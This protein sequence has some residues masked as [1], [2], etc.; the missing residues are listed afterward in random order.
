L[1]LIKKLD[2]HIIDLS[3]VGIKTLDL[4]ISSP[5]IQHS[6]GN[7]EGA[8]GAIDFGS[9]IG[10]RQIVGK[11]RAMSRDIPTFSL[12][13]DEVFA[14]LGSTQSFY[15]I[16]KRL[17]G[18]QWLVKTDGSF[19]IP[20]RSIFGNFEVHFIAIKGVA[21]SIMT[22]QQLQTKKI[23]T[24]DETWSWGMGLET[25]DDSEL[26]YNHTITPTVPIKIFNAGNVEVHPFES[27]LKITIK[28][29]VGTLGYLMLVNSNGSFIYIMKSVANSEVWI[30][31]GPNVK[32]NSLVAIQDTYKSFIHL[33]PGWNT[34]KLILTI[35]IDNVLVLM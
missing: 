10:T 29:V 9:T 27:Y 22:T 19:D 7:V 2:G 20:Q 23:N 13:R 32:R 1:V 34:L 35:Y 15:L 11:F 16:E 14:I 25:V 28:N 18:K 21:E 12:L 31:D 4:L 5:N 33:D 30:F 26:V 8:M 17:N 6:F 24:N 3:L